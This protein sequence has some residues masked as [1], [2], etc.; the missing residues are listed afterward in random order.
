MNDL[1]NSQRNKKGYL[2]LTETME[3]CNNGNIIFDPY[4]TLISKYSKIGKNNIFYPNVIIESEQESELI[5]GNGNIFY[6]STFILTSNSGII[7]LLDNNQF[8]GGVSIKANMKGAHISIRNNGR[9]LNGVQILGKCFL[10]NGAQVIGNITV[11]N[12]TLCDG[13]AYSHADADMRGG[14]L[15]GFG[16]ARDLIIS[17]GEVI[18]GFGKFI[19]DDIKKQ[20]FFHPKKD[21]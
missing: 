19:N 18:D 20:S 17:Q 4:S 9:Y 2:S 6:P 5:I 8:E 12:C 10:G 14:L 21:K 3:L 11:Q 16:I 13:E 15:K 1:I 7:S